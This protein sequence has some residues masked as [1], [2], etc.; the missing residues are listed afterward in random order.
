MAPLGRGVSGGGAQALPAE[1]NTVS[2]KLI[3]VI[4]S[5][6]KATFN[7]KYHKFMNQL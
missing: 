3:S 7:F 1:N 4:A 5:R 2:M 6:L